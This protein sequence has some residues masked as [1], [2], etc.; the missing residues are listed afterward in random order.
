L[1]DAH[2]QLYNSSVNL[3]L[4]ISPFEK[5]LNRVEIQQT[6]EIKIYEPNSPEA[7]GVVMRE[8]NNEG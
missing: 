3:M 8:V 2:T 4:P 1:V 5:E 7:S 6:G